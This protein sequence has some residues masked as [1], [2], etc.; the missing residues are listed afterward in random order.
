MRI[1]LKDLL[2]HNRLILAAVL[3]AVATCGGAAGQ[4]ETAEP[5]A[6]NEALHAPSTLRAEL[7]AGVWAARLGGEVRHD[8]GAGGSQLVVETE[9][10]LDDLEATANLELMLRKG[11]YALHL[12]GFGFSTS[13]R[14]AFDARPSGTGPQQFGSL[15]L[16]DGE[17]IRSD[18]DF[19]SAAVELQFFATDLQD[20]ELLDDSDV[21]LLLAPTLSARWV[22]TEHS[23]STLTA[24]DEV[25]GEWLAFM[26]GVSMQTEW[27]PDIDSP[28]LD[29]ITFDMSVAIGPAIGGMGGY[30]WQV[31]TGIHIGITP[32]FGVLFGYRLVEL[33]LENDD[34]EI[35]AGLQGL[36]LAGSVRF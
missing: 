30:I 33:N 34:Y 36:F 1:R 10:N 13:S 5:T 12:S 18:F 15:T 2:Q 31:R 8:T 24:S 28:W 9:L 3:A 35:E 32:Q 21:T 4:D 26:V 25:D 19:T 20:M 29:H 14:G 17:Q 6:L 27:R 22:H 7:L 16:T 11:D 23:I